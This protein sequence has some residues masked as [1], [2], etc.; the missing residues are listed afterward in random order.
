V[1][2]TPCAKEVVFHL[3]HFQNSSP[4]YFLLDLCQTKY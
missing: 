1:Q 4:F 3:A 2:S